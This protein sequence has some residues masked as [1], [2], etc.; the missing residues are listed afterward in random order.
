MRSSRVFI[1]L[2]LLAL[3][4]LP[5]AHAAVAP[6]V[7]IV[8][9]SLILYYDINNPGGYQGNGLLYNLADPV[10]NSYIGTINNSPTYS[11]TV[12]GSY[13]SFAGGAGELYPT[14]TRQYVSVG[15]MNPDY[16]NG[17]SVSFYATFGS[18]ADN[19]ERILDFGNDY[20]NSNILISRAGTDSTIYYESWPAGFNA[21]SNAWC[22]GPAT[23][24]TG[25]IVTNATPVFQQYTLVVTK[26]GTN[27]STCTWY[28]NGSVVSGVTTSGTNFL[29]VTTSR[30][31]N[32]IGRS[33]WSAD[34]YLEGKIMRLA[35]YNKAL[36]STEVTQNYNSMTDVTYPSS[37]TGSTASV[38]ENQTSAT[39]VSANES[40]TYYI[41]PGIDSSKFTINSSTGVLS[42]I[43]PPNYELPDDA[44]ANRVYQLTVRVIDNNGNHNDFSISI[45]VLNVPE[46]A[47]LTLPTLGSSGFKG[48]NLAVSVTPT[49]A[50]GS[51]TGTV[52]Y[53]F[54][55]KR[56]PKCF[57]VAYSGSGSS[58]CNFKPAITGY[59]EIS[60]VYTPNN[61]EYAPATVKQQFWFSKRTT[62][63]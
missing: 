20:Q 24:T 35:I 27:T 18:A 36:S 12:S 57:K 11:R 9:D 2:S 41:L 6:G 53:Y 59:K 8:S 5:S 19:W 48:V 10:S 43:A 17:F 30:S 21:G 25:A 61:A 16:S 7:G 28:L 38:N 63:R 50:A 52:S 37:I 1:L 60:V 3:L 54:A 29:P 45:T 26:T 33:N 51:S 14:S 44:D 42:F 47:S 46:F 55:G 62:N 49:V 23:G 39:T 15:T 58:T 34:T 4:F 22:K 56:I 31:R 40:G 13:L 32:W